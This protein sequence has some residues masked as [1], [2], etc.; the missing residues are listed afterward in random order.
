MKFVVLIALLLYVSCVWCKNNTTES[1]K[2]NITE[3]IKSDDVEGTFIEYLLSVY[4]N[5]NQ[6]GNVMIFRNGIPAQTGTW[7]SE[8]ILQIMETLIMFI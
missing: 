2:N 5:W 8:Q 3:S 4:S 1:I 7:R 6:Y